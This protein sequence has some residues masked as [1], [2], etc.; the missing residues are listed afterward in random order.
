MASFHD[1]HKGYSSGDL[2]QDSAL[3]AAR[4]M[5]KFL[6]QEEQNLPLSELLSGSVPDYDRNGPSSQYL[7][8]EAACDSLETVPSSTE[9]VLRVG[10]LRGTSFMYKFA[11]KKLWLWDVCDKSGVRSCS[12]IPSRFEIVAVGIAESRDPA[13]EFWLIVATVFDVSLFYF[14][15][16]AISEDAVPVLS[17]YVAGTGG[18]HICAI[19]DANASKR[20]FLGGHDG[21]V[22]ELVYT[23]ASQPK[24]LW[25]SLGF[26]SDRRCYLSVLSR[27]LSATLPPFLQTIASYISSTG[28]IRALQ[29]CASRN[30]L[31]VI[32]NECHLTVYSLA[33]SGSVAELSEY[34]I[35]ESI[36]SA[37]KATP[38]ASDFTGSTQVVE[39]IPSSPQVGGEVVC[40][41]VTRSGARVFV[42]SG[43]S[44]YGVSVVGAVN[45]LAVLTVRVPPVE[46]VVDSA[47]SPD[48]GRSVVMTGSTIAVVAPDESSVLQKQAHSGSQTG[49]FRERFDVV[50]IVGKLVAGLL[51]DTKPTLQM[52]D[53]KEGLL[54]ISAE[55]LVGG[56]VGSWRFIAVSTERELSLSPLTVSEQL[57]ELVKSQN[58]YAVR[59]FSIQYRPEHLA[60]L[61]V[62]MLVSAG[63]GAVLVSKSSSFTDSVSVESTVEKL[64][65]STETASAL[66]LIDA[67]GLAGPASGA[68]EMGPLGGVLQTETQNISAR[69]KG[70]A[71]LVSRLLRPLWFAKAF[72]VETHAGEAGAEYVVVKP[73]LG[74]AAR[75]FVSNLLRPVVQALT[76]FRFQLGEFGESKLIEGFIVLLNAVVEAMDLM[77][78]VET[79]Q[80]NKRRSEETAIV[81][82]T[83]VVAGIDSL[84]VRDLAISAGQGEPVLMALLSRA[85]IDMALARKHCPLI[86]T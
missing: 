34:T 65:F 54:S 36:K 79:G 77:R 75:Q 46:L 27:P 66:A 61:L 40:V 63:S 68:R 23:S 11:G 42:R 85:G 37:Y 62:G 7:V 32:S 80:L 19:S 21:S 2:W 35:G 55:P 10:S 1:A 53:L 48:S 76:Q 26:S 9:G 28:K 16:D 70:A 39:I 44:G 47:V 6:H 59:D 22:F 78:L 50:P 82:D 12:F 29:V 13:C 4:L 81:D 18:A 52:T 64:L 51:V 31:F 71:I 24:S 67:P 43:R 72:C 5:E 74:S 15:P 20:I 45:Q 57:N 3:N 84:L 58:L 30:L 56:P 69:T 73:A 49:K 38:S 83:A 14:N 25:T 60:A 86:V 41:L 17:G 33:T 8:T